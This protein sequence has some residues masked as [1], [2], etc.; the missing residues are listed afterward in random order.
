[1]RADTKS[2]S[3]EASV[4]R[5][6]AFLSD[7]TDL[8]RWA[9]GFAKGVRRTENGWLV[10]TTGGDMPIRIARDDATGVVDFLFSPSPGVDV[11]AASRVIARGRHCE[12]VFTLDREHRLAF[13]LSDVFDMPHAE[14]AD[15]C[16]V[17]A[18]VY[19]QRLSRAR[20][21]L[22]AFTRNYCGLVND[23]APCRC[24]KRVARAAALGRLHRSRPELVALA[25]ETVSSATLEME[26]LHSA[27]QVMR[28]HL[29]YVAPE[30]VTER[31]RGMLSGGA[32]TLLSPAPHPP[33]PHQ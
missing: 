1:M 21:A 17:S 24:G 23:Q 25:T 5:V 7:P 28:Q 3:I 32:R 31:L 12:Y 9:V 27:A 18:D 15:L 14:A 10:E 16:D 29:S 4:R 26:G 6:A 13:V 33:S 20:R 19:H 2:I 8:P 11:L 22:E 30:R